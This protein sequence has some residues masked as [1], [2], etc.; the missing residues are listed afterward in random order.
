SVPLIT[1][2]R[3]VG[4]ITLLTTAD[5]RRIF[6]EKD[7]AFMEDL[8][9]RVAIAID[10]ARLYSNAQEAIKARD[11]FLSIASHEL[12][13]PLTSMQLQTQMIFRILALKGEEV[14]LSGDRMKKF[15]ELT[16]KQVDRLSVL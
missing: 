16:H 11:E 10:N 7:L 8:A 13:T 12:K 2:R 4:V 1:R 5:S 6:R 3:I 9:S 14:A 15:V